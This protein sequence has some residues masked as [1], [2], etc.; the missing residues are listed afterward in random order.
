MFVL[1]DCIVNEYGIASFMSKLDESHILGLDD[2][3]MSMAGDHGR[4]EYRYREGDDVEVEEV[5]DPM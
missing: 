3:S 4:D 2:T 1:D 5:E